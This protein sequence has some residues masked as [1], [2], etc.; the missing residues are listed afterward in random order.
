MPSESDR[1]LDD[2]DRLIENEAAAIVEES[3]L[4]EAF[5]SVLVQKICSLGL[6]ELILVPTQQRERT[7]LFCTA[8]ERLATCWLALA[9]KQRG[10]VTRL[11][12]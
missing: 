5:P 11:L 12:G 6:P 8:I 9:G 4:H 1:I 2:I 10:R 3:E 7:S